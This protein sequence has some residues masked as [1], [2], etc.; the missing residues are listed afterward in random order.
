MDWTDLRYFQA[1]VRGGSLSAA[2]R[3]LHV[4]HATVSRRI[5]ALEDDLNLKLVDRRGRRW[6]LTAD[7]GR[8]AAIAE[9]METE[10]QGVDR[11]AEASRAGLS[12]EVTVSAPPS[13][14]ARGLAPVVV[15]LRET[16]PGLRLRIIGESRMASLE[17][18]EADIAIRLSRPTRGA[19]TAVKI[20]KAPFHLY[21]NPDYLA[22]TAPED[23]TF[24]AYD[25]EM[26]P[27]PQ[28]VAL[29]RLAGSRPITVRASTADIQH[30]IARGGGGVVMLPDFMADDDPLLVQAE[31]SDIAIVRDIWLIV[32]SDMKR[33]A[34]VRAVVDSLRDTF[35]I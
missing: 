32:H 16:Y 20:G 10:A 23:W 33:S 9:R 1:W 5:T 28:Q 22:A 17:R 12:G 6:S 25:E 30:A 15:A 24:I 35:S 11:L 26:E 27:A 8:V 2:A 18:R 19:L 29:H 3:T 4:E 21:A 31:P 13:L 7:G 14:A 34:A